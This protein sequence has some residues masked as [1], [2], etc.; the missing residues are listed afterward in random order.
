M[1]GRA[2]RSGFTEALSR[3]ERIP[4]NCPFKCI[5]T[6]AAEKSPYC[7]ALALLNARRGDMARGFAFAGANAYRVDRIMSVK[8]LIRT[9][10]A[11]YCMDGR[12]DVSSAEALDERLCSAQQ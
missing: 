9:I 4:L 12:D 5:T 3:G 10:L 7:I 11:E 2:L 6:C 1:P 8:D